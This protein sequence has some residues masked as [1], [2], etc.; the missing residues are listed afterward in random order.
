MAKTIK[1][2]NGEAILKTRVTYGM[3]KKVNDV[4]FDG[5]NFS[6]SGQSKG[7]VPYKNI[8][9]QAQTIVLVLLE[10]ITIDEKEMPITETTLEDLPLYDY[11]KLETEAAKIMTPQSDQKK[12]N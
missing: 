8:Q 5:V 4:L 3:Q 2:S 9:R 6:V 7:E 11:R 1:L 10:K 12:T